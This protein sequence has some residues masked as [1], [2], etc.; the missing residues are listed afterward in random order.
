LFAVCF[1]GAAEFIWNANSRVL[2]VRANDGAAPHTVRHLLLDQ[3]LP[4]VMAHIGHT[5][6]HASCILTEWGA[7][8]FV[9]RS[10]LGKST[11]SAA[12]ESLGCKILS[13]DGVAVTVGN[14][15]VDAC[16]TYPSL[17]L[18]PD[19]VMKIFGS[20]LKTT[21]M[22]DYCSKR[23]VHA[24]FCSEATMSHPLRAVY[25]LEGCGSL[26]I[27]QLAGREAC[28]AILGN[29]FLLDVNDTQRAARQLQSAGQILC[30]VPVFSLRY[31]RQFSEL[32][33]VC[34][35]LVEHW[36]SLPEPVT[37]EAS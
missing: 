15:V 8:A 32:S 7:V 24:E 11:I 35:A 33:Q 37:E 23:R 17:R 25:A 13:D 20:K 2:T 4:R 3:V 29:A 6:L 36:S 10:G 9:G 18:M 26:R 28:A 5:V 19:S 31:P 22:A 1:P 12:L 34:N 21:A 30:K 27:T 16:A 14:S